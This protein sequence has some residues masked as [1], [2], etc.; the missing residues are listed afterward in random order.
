MGRFAR[1]RV[2]A[3]VLATMAAVASA[4]TAQTPGL[5]IR[6]DPNLIG[7]PSS[8]LV[9]AEG[10]SGQTDGRVPRSVVLSVQR[11][12]VIDPR[13]RAARCSPRQARNFNCP[14]ASRIGGGQA[15]VTASG[16]IIP[17]GSQDFTASIDLFLAPPPRNHDVAGL[18]V[19][20][21]EPTT[22]QRGT[23]TGRIVRRG[24]GP[25][26]YELRFEDLGAGQAPPPGIT[27]ELK[28]LDLRTGARRSVV[29]GRGDNRH[30]VTYSL[31][32]NPSACDGTWNGH[33][34]LSFS[35]GSSEERGLSAACRRR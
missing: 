26:G 18:V 14:R 33:A 27:I 30:R 6:L 4:A 8:L 22:G 3:I 35:D 15:V 19:A 28:R 29:V 11:G 13:S 31:I 7:R 17:G 34:V 24:S 9:E 10:Q 21:E 23:A 1:K 20:I 16:A 12:F 25:Y 2:L 32:T 5:T